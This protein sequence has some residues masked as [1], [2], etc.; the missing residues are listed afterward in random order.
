[1]RKVG[2]SLVSSDI[3]GTDGNRKGGEAL[4]YLTVEPEQIVPVGEGAAG[5]V[6][7]FGTVEAD[8][9]GTVCQGDLYIVQQGN[10]GAEANGCPVSG[11]GRQVTQFIQF[12]SLDAEIKAQPLVFAFDLV[13]GVDIHT[14][15]VAVDDDLITVR[16]MPDLFP[17]RY[18][19][20]YPERFCHD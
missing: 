1:V 2:E 11:N 6:R 10:V 19:G 17:L 18:Q 8:S 7:E 3:Q 4:Q 9:F 14:P 13:V 5:H 12:P 15:G 16:Y 20:R